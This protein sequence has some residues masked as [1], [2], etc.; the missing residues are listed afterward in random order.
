MNKSEQFPF[1][2]VKL[3]DEMERCKFL[4][5][6]PRAN[7]KIGRDIEHRLPEGVKRKGA[8]N[9][10]CIEKE[11]FAKGK[12]AIREGVVIPTITYESEHGSE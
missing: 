12:K 4:I 3:T 8:L 5:L 7:V 2:K 9:K 11:M 6:A 1:T 10:L